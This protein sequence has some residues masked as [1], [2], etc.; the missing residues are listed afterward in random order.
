VD[1]LKQAVKTGNGPDR[2]VRPRRQRQRHQP[3]GQG[4]PDQLRV[5]PEPA[6]ECDGLRSHLR[7]QLRPLRRQESV[8][9]GG[10]VAERSVY[11]RQRCAE[12]HQ[13]RLRP[14]GPHGFQDS[15]RKDHRRTST[16]RGARVCPRSSTTPTVRARTPATATTRTPTSRR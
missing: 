5:R 14:A 13:V 2:D 16:A 3:D 8:T 1:R 10:D 15:R 11:E 9:S 7:L 6:V 4:R 12:V